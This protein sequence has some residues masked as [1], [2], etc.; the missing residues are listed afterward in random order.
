LH[1]LHHAAVDAYDLSIAQALILIPLFWPV[2]LSLLSSL[3]QPTGIFSSQH[4]IANPDVVA[5]A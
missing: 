1:G 5:Q 4:A 2:A 3:F